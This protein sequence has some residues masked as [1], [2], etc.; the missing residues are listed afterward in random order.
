M[1][2]GHYGHVIVPCLDSP[3][4]SL[5]RKLPLGW[6]LSAVSVRPYSMKAGVSKVVA[7]LIQGELD[8]A[9]ASGKYSSRSSSK[10]QAE[11]RRKA[12]QIVARFK[13]DS[14][15]IEVLD[16]LRKV[17]RIRRDSVSVVAGQPTSRGSFVVDVWAETCTCSLL[18]PCKHMVALRMLIKQK[19][20]RDIVYDK[21]LDE[22][23]LVED[24]DGMAANEGVCGQTQDPNEAKEDDLG[25][26]DDT[27]ECIERV[28]EEKG[29]FLDKLGVVLEEYG[30][31]AEVLNNV[32]HVLKT[33]TNMLDRCFHPGG[34]RPRAFYMRPGSIDEQQAHV[35][36][37]RHRSKGNERVS[38]APNKVPMKGT[39]LRQA[40][41]RGNKRVNLPKSNVPKKVVCECKVWT[42]IPTGQDSVHCQNCSV[43]IQRP[44]SRDLNE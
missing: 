32:A 36:A 28:E 39:S 12:E 23:G 19:L 7:A 10:E 15:L 30:H 44:G 8:N 18:L 16:P 25:A 34:S 38:K 17:F 33:A 43:V 29:I 5:A 3:L 22:D 21:V 31:N 24:E 14:S 1:M 9:G 40:G 42:I 26:V 2:V 41:Y 27:K 37:R 35:Q 13:E 11:R 4:A 6:L 20:L